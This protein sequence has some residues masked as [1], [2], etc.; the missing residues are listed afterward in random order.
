[1]L[2]FLQITRK[3]CEEELLKI[4]GVISFTFVMNKSRCIIRCKVELSPE[5]LCDAIN[6]TKVLSAQQV[7]RNERGEEVGT[8]ILIY[9]IG[10]GK[11]MEP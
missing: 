7:V 4:K 9:L 11:Q 10:F 3:L 2:F 5:M 6:K 1:M 8:L